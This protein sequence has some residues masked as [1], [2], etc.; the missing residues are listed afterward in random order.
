MTV[1]EVL[2]GRPFFC[3]YYSDGSNVCY[4]KYRESTLKDHKRYAADR[5]D[6]AFAIVMLGASIRGSW[7][8]ED[9]I[10]TSAVDAS[11]PREY[12]GSCIFSDGF[13]C[14]TPPTFTFDPATNT[15]FGLGG[16]MFRG[17]AYSGRPGSPIKFASQPTG[18]S[19]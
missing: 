14:S 11:A 18:P 17:A 16:A 7:R 8:K 1:E 12:I 19:Q 13:E 15:S 5:L 3:Q 10:F 6:P 4:Y 9:G 2:G